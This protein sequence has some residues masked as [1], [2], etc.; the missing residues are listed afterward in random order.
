MMSIFQSLFSFRDKA[1][2]EV[3]DNATGL[4]LL[5]VTTKHQQILIRKESTIEALFRQI[6]HSCTG[7][8]AH[9]IQ[10]SINLFGQKLAGGQ[11]FEYMYIVRK[12]ET[13]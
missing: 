10:A 9:I 8:S 2:P 13:S 7:L 5:R 4:F 1:A 6:G 12:N 11:N 3:F